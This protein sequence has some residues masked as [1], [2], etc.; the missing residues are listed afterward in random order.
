[1]IVAVRG[2]GIYFLYTPFRGRGKVRFFFCLTAN[3]NIYGSAHIAMAVTGTVY[4]SIN[5]VPGTGLQP[6]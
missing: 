6:D 2:N 3:R 4:G 1:M 5:C